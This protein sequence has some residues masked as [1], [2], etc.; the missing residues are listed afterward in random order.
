[1]TTALYA[2]TLFVS[3]FLLFC[4]EPLV[5]K[6]LLPVAG[7]AAAVWSTCLVF[8]QA[9]LLA[10][11][12]FTTFAS[13]RFGARRHAVVYVALFVA[14]L[15]MPI[16]FHGA[17]GAHPA[18]RVLV[19]LTEGAFVPFFVLST[20]APA[21]Q[22]WF[23]GT[24]AAHAKDPYF[25]YAASNTGSIAGLAAY[26]L[27][28]EPSFDLSVQARM[29][30]WAFVPLG[31]LV[32]LCALRVRGDLPLAARDSGPRLARARVA[33]WLV[34]AAV[35]SAQLV[36]VTTYL[37]TEV[38]PAPL[39]WVIPLAAYLLSFVLVFS[40]TRI[41]SHA[42]IAKRVPLAAVVGMLLVL[43]GANQPAALVLALHVA[44]LFWI[45]AYCHGEI[46]ADRPPPA[47][48]PEYYAWMSLGGVAGGALV[49]LGAPLVFKQPIEY[50]L[51]FPF[52]V[53]CLPAARAKRWGLAV[54]AAAIAIAAIGPWAS[55]KT[56]LDLGVTKLVGLPL[57]V[58]FAV[59]RFPRLLAWTLAAV[60]FVV[61]GTADARAHVV[62]RERSFFGAFHVMREPDGVALMHGNTMHGFQLASAPRTP[63]LYYAQSGP[64]GDVL[65]L[66]QK[67]ERARRVAVIG[68]GIGSLASYARP[69]ERWRFFELDP[70]VVAI[71]TDRRYFTFLSDAFGDRPDIVVGDARIELA[72]DEGGFDLLVVDAFTSDSIP[73]HLL[74]REAFAMYRQK[75]APG[76]MV[77]WHVS[78]RHLDLFP[79]LATLAG[80]AGWAVL[81]REDE[82]ADA[83]TRKVSSRWV[84][85]AA[86]ADTLFPLRAHGWADVPQRAGFRC[87]TDQRASIVTVFR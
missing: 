12:V 2:V 73:T 5:A 53:A 31:A 18:V 71:A 70:A 25:L 37:T 11:Y 78:N 3:A 43:T 82:A 85:M 55:A 35:P 14:A 59:D 34:L 32:G 9:T 21:V 15:A 76:A 10:G 84:A 67:E 51:C 16:A 57:V 38:A 30:R 17:I 44:I 36:A 74:T 50:P 66:A 54:A 20:L 29:L 4:I 61:T 46:A 87:W 24:G 79:E 7:G 45:S 83:Q 81:A 33:R 75:L 49:A 22:R 8:F 23:S 77:A 80:D 65:A 28:L 69:G 62:R 52:A 39:L 72:K 19:L 27:V 56:H 40:R 48:L 68:L 64:I 42:A 63:T 41:V 26:P 60:L 13:R 86:Q 47:R 6:M 1:M 58:A